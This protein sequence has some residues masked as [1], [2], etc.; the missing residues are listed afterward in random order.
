M[1]T[2]FDGVYRSDAKYQDHE[3]T[4]YHRLTQPTED[5]ILERN[6]QLRLNPGAL[7][8][9][10]FGRQVA[11]IPF[12]L[13]DKAAAMGFDVKSKDSE[14]ASKEIIRF[15]TTTPE[16]RCCLVNDTKPGQI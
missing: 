16:G 15:L 3:D 10:S 5:M 13:Y 1:Q 7:K 6:K 8:S 9:L 2:E 14:I 4:L 11:S 12:I